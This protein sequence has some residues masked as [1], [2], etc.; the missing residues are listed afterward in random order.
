MEIAD[1]ESEV[2]ETVEKYKIHKTDWDKWDTVKFSQWMENVKTDRNSGI[3]DY[4]D[5]FQ[6]YFKSVW[7]SVFLRENQ[8]VQ[9]GDPKLLG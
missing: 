2:S 7:M 9:T 4:S 3:N 1:G 6:E 8:R 5:S